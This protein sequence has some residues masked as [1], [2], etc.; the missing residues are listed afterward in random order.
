MSEGRTARI[1]CLAAVTHAAQYLAGMRPEADLWREFGELIRRFFEADV[2]AIAE[3]APDGLLCFSYASPADES[4]RLRLLEAVRRLGGPVLDSGFLSTEIIALPERHAVALLPVVWEKGADALLIV[5]HVGDTPLPRDLLDVYL[6]V[7]RLI[8]STLTRIGFEEQLKR[9]A[10]EQTC[11]ADLGRRALEGGEIGR[12]MDEAVEQVAQIMAVDYCGLFELLPDGST[13]LL[14]AGFGWKEGLVGRATIEAD[15]GTQPGYTLRSG[16]SAAEA[17]VQAERFAAPPLFRAHAVAASATVPLAGRERPMGVMGVHTRTVRTFTDE[18]VT[19]LQSAANVVATAW[20]RKQAEDRIRESEK[21]FRSMTDTSPLAIYMSS[22]IEQK[23]EYINPTFTRLFGYTLD[24]VPT[25]SHW[26][27]L[28]Y[29]DQRYRDRIVEE[30]QRKVAQAIETNS[31]IEPMAVV[32]TCKDGSKK[33][34]LWGYISTGVQNWAFGLDLTDR[35]RAEE[36]LRAANAKLTN[37]LEELR[38]TQQQ[39]IQSEKLAALGTLAAG[40]A[41]ELNNPL[42]GIMGYVTVACEATQEP[43]ARALLERASRE[44]ERMRD[45]IRNMLGFARPVVEGKLSAVDVAAVLERTL[46]LLRAEFKVRDITVTT[47]VAADLPKVTAQAEY[48]Q[49]ALLNLLMNARDAVEGRPERQ[50]RIAAESRGGQVVVRVV[51]TGPGIPPERQGRI[52]DPFFTTK[53]PGKGTGLGLS[54]ARNI[55]ADLGGSLTCDSRVGEGA[56]FTLMLPSEGAP[57]R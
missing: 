23:A 4:A 17:N 38:A 16:R 12:L 40:V 9:R 15:P 28:A 52:F 46:A 50:I 21:K 7:A 8:G 35:K 48:L 42:M 31:A 27:P 53:P 25:V 26:W 24:D 55:V 54:I 29:P 41:H 20:E 33:N 51:D 11:I 22:G 43:Q 45:L 3:R 47:E 39:V 34:I 6:A 1:D 13:L 14:R 56:T 44:L 37:T 32:V 5:G 49:Q 2:V 10:R 19:F 30:W 36:A 57:A 18:E